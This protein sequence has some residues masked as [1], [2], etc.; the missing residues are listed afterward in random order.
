MQTLPTL[1]WQR[2][3]FLC[4]LYLGCCINELHLPHDTF[5]GESC[6]ILMPL[7]SLVGEILRVLE[8]VA[9]PVVVGTV[10]RVERVVLTLGEVEVILL[11]SPGVIDLVAVEQV[12]ELQSN[13][14]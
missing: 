7:M 12:A 11:V 13:R 4:R 10:T 5:E 3:S 8:E 2:P 9:V 6:N 14:E 1:G